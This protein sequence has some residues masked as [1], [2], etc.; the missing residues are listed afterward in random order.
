MEKVSPTGSEKA[1]L[2]RAASISSLAG[3]AVLASL[4]IITGVLAGSLAVLGDGIDSSVDVLISVMTLI[5]SRIIARPADKEHPWGHGRAETIATG[6]LACLLFFC[7]AELIRSSALNLVDGIA[8]GRTVDVPEMPALIVTVISIAGK[9]LL[10]LS[11]RQFGKRAGSPMLEAN[12]NNM[13]ADVLLSVGVLVGLGA[14]ILTG[15][16]IIDSVFA[17]LVGAWV[18]K[19]SIGIFVEANVELMDSGADSD[20][21]RAVFEAVRSVEGAGNPHRA[22]MRKIAG[23]WDI[24]LDIEVDPSLSVHEGHR[25]ASLVEKAIKANVPDVFDIMVHVEPEGDMRHE[26]FGLSEGKL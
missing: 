5:V 23:H 19:S 17:L 7:G 13:V 11:Q 6:L 3:N 12:A 4:K 9:L 16:G 20:S 8:S 10:A 21:Y 22:R 15:I 24:D 26:Q 1:V 2:I 25:I 14:S 18:I